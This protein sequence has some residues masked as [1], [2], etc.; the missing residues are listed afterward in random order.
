MIKEDITPADT[1]TSDA[2]YYKYRAA[3]SYMY[4]V[5]ATKVIKKLKEGSDNLTTEEKLFEMKVLTEIIKKI[6]MY[7]PDPNGGN[8]KKT[9]DP[10]NPFV[11]ELKTLRQI[12]PAPPSKS[13]KHQ[14]LQEGWNDKIFNALQNQKSKYIT[15][16]AALEISGARPV[17]L[18][19]GILMELNKDGAI[20]I[21]IK[22]AK[23]HN[24][25]YGQETRSFCIISDS[26]AFQYLKDELQDQGEC[27]LSMDVT[28]KAL[29]QKIRNLSL[30]VFPKNK[31]LISPYSYRHL[32]SQRAKGSLTDEGV[33]VVQK[34]MSTEEIAIILGHCNDKSQKWYKNKSK[35]GSS[36]FKITNIEGSKKVK[37][38]ENTEKFKDFLDAK[39]KNNSQRM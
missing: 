33:S 34:T 22:G 36:G 26:L 19:D 30:E 10:D 24:G 27:K 15:I 37:I 6:K 20:K 1:F 17:E 18:R 3:W 35:K 11:S 16:I 28:E 21:T 7:P 13:K 25:K 5:M 32:F 38:T 2:T 8:L 14:K 23:T 39:N 9:L 12:T 4:T 29:G 31:S